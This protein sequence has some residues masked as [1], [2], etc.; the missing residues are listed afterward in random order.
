MSFVV[1]WPFEFFGIK[2]I[3]SP[4]SSLVIALFMWRL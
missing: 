3:V 2:W 4:V 1:M